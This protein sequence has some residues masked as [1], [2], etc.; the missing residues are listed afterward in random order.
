MRKELANL[1]WTFEALGPIVGNADSF[2]ETPCF[3]KAPPL[4][5]SP[6]PF[7]EAILGFYEANNAVKSGQLVRLTEVAWRTGL[8]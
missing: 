6:G 8:R 5:I 4:A 7:F 3:A 1:V 2:V